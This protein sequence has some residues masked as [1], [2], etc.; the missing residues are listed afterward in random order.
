MREGYASFAAV[1][2]RERRVAGLPPYKAMAL[3]RA[4]APSATAP[5]TF[6]AAAAPLL[7]EACGPKVEVLGPVPAPMERRAGRYRAQLLLLSA[8]RAALQKGLAG[9][10][11]QLQT[12]KQARR[13]RWSVDVDPAETY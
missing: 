7:A 13:V 4:E 8:E 9:A 6:L 3:L 10:L 11:P 12:L 1:A 2:L 5:Q